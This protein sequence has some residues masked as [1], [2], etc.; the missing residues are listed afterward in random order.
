MGNKSWNPE[1]TIF[2]QINNL[3]LKAQIN[4]WAADH[5]FGVFTGSGCDLIAVGFLFA[6]I[7]I[8]EIGDKVWSDYLDYLRE[9]EDRTPCVVIDVNMNETTKDISSL[10][11]ASEHCFSDLNRFL[12]GLLQE[13]PNVR[14]V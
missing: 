11:F 13:G 7:E 3:D 5:G 10:H 8:R 9:S 2:L 4:L 12:D 14:G 1:K 6:I